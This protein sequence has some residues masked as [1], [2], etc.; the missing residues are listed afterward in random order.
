MS[1]LR[2]ETALD[3]IVYLR[4]IYDDDLD[5]ACAIYAVQDDPE[6]MTLQIASLLAG[7]IRAAGNAE[8]TWVHLREQASAIPD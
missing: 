2:R 5:G 4:A 1:L 3:A 8:A 7:A 6:L